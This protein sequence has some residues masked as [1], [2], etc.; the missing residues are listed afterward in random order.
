[1]ER[2]HKAIYCSRCGDEIPEEELQFSSGSICALC[3]H[4]RQEALEV[5]AKKRQL[6]SQ[7]PLPDTKATVLVNSR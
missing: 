6:P 7:N 1:M 5:F 3:A 4:M 2:V